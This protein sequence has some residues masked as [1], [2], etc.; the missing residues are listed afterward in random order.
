MSYSFNLLDEKWIPCR[1]GAGERR[2][3]KLV[4]ALCQSHKTREILHP[5]PLVTVALHRLLLAV[6]HRIFGPSGWRAWRDIWKR[7]S[8]DEA[9]VKKYLD[10]WRDRFDLFDDKH[11]FYQTSAVSFDKATSTAKLFHELASGHNPTLF[12]HTLM[13]TPPVLTA[14][15]AARLVVAFQAYA[16]PGL[17]SFEQGREKVDRSAESAFMVK[18]AAILVVGQN[19]FE[20]L[21]LNLVQ[22]NAEDE[23]PFGFD[24]G[25]D[26]PTWERDGDVKAT[27]RLPDGYLDWLTWQSRRVR[28]KPETDRQGRLVVRNAVIMKGLQL[29]D[30]QWRYGRETMIAFRKN[31]KA[32]A[33]VE[34]WSA[35][36]FTEDKALW[37]DTLSLFQSVGNERV[38]PKTV[39]W[40]A[41]LKAHGALP[42]GRTLQL[43]ALGLSTDRAR[44]DFWRHEDLPLPLEYLSNEELV[45]GLKDALDVAEETGR[46]LR[47]A[48][49]LLARLTLIPDE[50]KVPG[51]EAKKDING[52]CDDLAAGRPYWSRLETHFKRLLEDLPGDTSIDEYGSTR[53]LRGWAATIRRAAQEAFDIA[54][55]AVGESARALKARARAE[56]VFRRRLYGILKPY[57]E[58]GKE[59]GEEE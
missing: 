19:L 17:V 26:K 50:S 2:E 28:L 21:M 13:S 43:S 35:L 20:T 12:D 24:P 58:D 1:M 25:K 29:P 36:A 16:L 33:E 10:Q 32:T 5:S 8:F 52:M 7:G 47:D 30:K 42:K 18:G 54:S 53:R 34:P 23:E 55:A 59:G 4:D 31:A 48:T 56:S 38:R 44:V 9:R 14:A 49:W 3:M 37:R 46:T 27:D 22:Y 39:E 11:P 15:E 6:L 51:K 41:D 40:L 57:T 45:S